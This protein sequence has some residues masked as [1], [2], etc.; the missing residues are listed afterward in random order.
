MK[1]GTGNEREKRRGVD[2]R[3]DIRPESN[4]CPPWA[5]S[6]NVVGAT[7]C[8]TVPPFSDFLRTILVLLLLLMMMMMM[9]MMIFFTT[10]VVV[11]AGV[12]LL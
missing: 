8:A 3:N 7:G 1:N 4:L 10:L 9:T 5:S 6:P 11:V 12:L 2:R